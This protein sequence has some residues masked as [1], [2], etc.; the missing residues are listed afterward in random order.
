M[1]FD[2]KYFILKTNVLK[3]YRECIKFTYNIKDIQSRKEMQDYI[4]F[5]FD[6]SKNEENQKKIQYLIANCRKKLNSFKDSH[7]L[8][9]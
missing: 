2:L 8:M 1:K 5:E 6:S 4:R 7:N 9:N 3:V